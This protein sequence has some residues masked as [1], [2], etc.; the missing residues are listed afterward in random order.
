MG[1]Y[2]VPVPEHWLILGQN[3]VA[4][5]LLNTSP[6]RPQRDGKFHTT[7]VI[8]IFPFRDRPAEASRMDYWLSL[9]RQWLVREQ[10]K[11]VEEKTLKLG[12][13]SITCIGGRVLNAIL[14]DK[15]NHPET[16]IISLDCMSE[17]G[18]NILF[19]GEPSDVQFFY[20]FLSQIRRRR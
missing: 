20:T 10:A 8:D 12:E 4:F 9:K 19:D 3:S 7:A 13:E 1:N 14:R 17:R 2:E 5:T 16:D 15:P 11:S 18:L 6:T